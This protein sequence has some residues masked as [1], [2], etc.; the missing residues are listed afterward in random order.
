MYSLSMTIMLCPYPQQC[1]DKMMKLVWYKLMLS[2]IGRGLHFVLNKNREMFFKFLTMTISFINSYSPFI[3]H[4]LWKWCYSKRVYNLVGGRDYHQF[5]FQYS[6]VSAIIK[7]LIARVSHR[8][9][10]KIKIIYGMWAGNSA[11]FMENKHKDK[12]D[13]KGWEYNRRIRVWAYIAM[14]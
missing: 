5:F 14:T 4:L 8:K 11:L 10:D 13:L 9:R 3:Q 6:A 1:Y 12:S 2:S 7:L